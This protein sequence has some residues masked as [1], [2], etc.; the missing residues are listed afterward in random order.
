[1]NSLN[2]AITITMNMFML[3]CHTIQVLNMDCLS[4]WGLDL[5]TST[6]HWAK[7]SEEGAL[8]TVGMGVVNMGLG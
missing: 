3:G 2:M 7:L 1:M 5:S 4:E 8:S 6:V